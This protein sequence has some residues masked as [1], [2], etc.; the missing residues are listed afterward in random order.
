MIN[1]ENEVF[2]CKEG[3]LRTSCQE[4]RL[5]NCDD[6]LVHLTNNAVQKKAK[7]YGKFEDGNILDFDEFQSIIDQNCKA[8]NTKS[9]VSVRNDLV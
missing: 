1:Q 6:P 5:D 7:T 9:T 3:Y 8:A 2:F 4:Y